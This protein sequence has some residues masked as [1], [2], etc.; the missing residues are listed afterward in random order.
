MRVKGLAAEKSDDRH[1]RLLRA[2]SKRPRDRRAAEQCDELA[3]SHVLLSA[4]VLKP[5]TALYEMPHCAA[6]QIQAADVSSGSM[7][8]IKSP[9]RGLRLLYWSAWHATSIPFSQRSGWSGITLTLPTDAW[10]N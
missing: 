1:R 2:R 4:G 6:Q 3:P 5:I 8:L 10:R 7:V 9:M